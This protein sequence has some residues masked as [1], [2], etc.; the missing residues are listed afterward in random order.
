M[1]IRDSTSLTMQRLR[2]RAISSGR[3]GTGTL[4]VLAERLLA[5]LVVIAAILA[6]LSIVGFNLTTVLALS[7]IHI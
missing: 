7:L 4:M 6:I 2:I 5:A 1:C 3:V